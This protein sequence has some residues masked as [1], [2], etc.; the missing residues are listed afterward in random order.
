MHTIKDLVAAVAASAPVAVEFGPGIDEY[1][2]YAEPGMRGLIVSARL[3][4]PDLAQLYVDF[5]AFAQHNRA[6]ESAN[7]YDQEGRPRLTAR[8]AGQYSPQDTPYPLY[9]APNAPL[10]GVLTLLDAA[11]AELL[12]RYL[13]AGSGSTCVRWLEDLVLA[14]EARLNGKAQ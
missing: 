11:R 2:S 6:L 14:H 13:A 10:Q 1:E 4:N 3:I 5:E 9:L 7:Y 12:A 8:E